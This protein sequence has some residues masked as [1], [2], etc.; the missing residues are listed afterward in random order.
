MLQQRIT[1]SLQASLL[2]LSLAVVHMGG[3]VLGNLGIISDIFVVVGFAQTVRFFLSSYIR[4]DV[5][6]AFEDFMDL[7]EVSESLTDLISGVTKE[8]TSNPNNVL[9]NL[10]LEEPEDSYDKLKF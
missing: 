7:E 6:E 3:S 9:K 4:E 1:L 2:L 8:D 5:S 10:Q